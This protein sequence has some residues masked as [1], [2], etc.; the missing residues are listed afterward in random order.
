MSEIHFIITGGTIDS[1]FDPARA[2][3]VV[4]KKTILP[5]YLEKTIKSYVDATFE[6]ICMLD[7]RELT[8]E[9]REQIIQ[10][11]QTSKSKKILIT[12]GTDTMPETA[13]F[14]AKGLGKTDKTIILTGSMIP[15]KEFAMSDAGFNLG[16]AIANVQSAP[17][18]VYIAMNAR[19]F[20]AEQVVKN[21]KIGRFETQGA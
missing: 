19:L 2:T 10:A 5:Q 12:H 16:Y 7:S 21:K 9:I 13:R 3:T 6:E 17:A 4:N 11:I 8:D 20:T 14:I 1:H 18:G 15:I